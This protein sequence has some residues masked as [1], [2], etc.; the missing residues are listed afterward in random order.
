MGGW[1][2][3][4]VGGWGAH[5]MLDPYRFR[6]YSRARTQPNT[7][8]HTHTFLMHPPRGQAADQERERAEERAAAAEERA[9]AAEARAAATTAR[10]GDMEVKTKFALAA[11]RGEGG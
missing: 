8:T 5:H 4:G 11:K 3:L 1:V 10:L 2:V 7:H 6:K 9:A